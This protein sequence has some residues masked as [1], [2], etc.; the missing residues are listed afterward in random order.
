MTESVDRGCGK[1]DPEQAAKR[2]PGPLPSRTGAELGR[3]P[4]GAAQFRNNHENHRNRY[5]PRTIRQSGRYPSLELT[6]MSWRNA[7]WFSAI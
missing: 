6:G 3:I 4:S 1:M 7:R 5:K 2:V